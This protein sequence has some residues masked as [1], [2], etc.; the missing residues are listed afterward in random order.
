V[1]SFIAFALWAVFGVIGDLFSWAGAVIA[2][3]S[4]VPSGDLVL[5]FV[6]DDAACTHFVGACG[7]VVEHSDCRRRWRKAAMARSV[8]KNEG[9]A[10]CENGKLRLVVNDDFA[11]SNKSKASRAQRQCL[12]R[13][14]CKA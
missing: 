3:A 10:A 13:N 12:E 6:F 7:A 4:C 5:A 11:T 9:D 2:I 14:E 8:A 1:D